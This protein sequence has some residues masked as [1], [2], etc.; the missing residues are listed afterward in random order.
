MATRRITSVLFGDLVGFTHLT[1]SRDQEDAREL[2]SHYFDTCRRIVERYG[3]TVEKF[4]GDA[5]MAV[6]G[7]P[8]AHEDDAERAV[9]AGLELVNAVTSIGDELGV[10]DLAMRVGIV[11]GEVAVTIGAEQQGM[12]AGDAVNT[13]ARVQSVAAPHQVWVDETTRL[14]TSA[15]ITYL[16]VGSHALKGKADPVPLW[17]V[18]AVVAAVGGAQRADG[19]E[20]PLIGRERELRMVKE[21]FHASEESGRPALL[22]MVGEPGVGKSRLAWEFEK[23]VD[24]LLGSVRWHSGRCVSYGE[25]VAYYALAEAFRGRLQML[26]SAPEDGGEEDA[27]RLLELGLVRYVADEAERD[28]LRPRVAALLGTGSVAGFPREDLFSA[29]TVFLERVAEGYPL[30]LVIDDAQHADDGLLHFVEHVISVAA[31][32]CFVLLLTRPGLV[33]ARPS[34]ATNHRATVSHL[35]VMREDEVAEL[36]D[37]LVAGVPASVR[38]SLVARSE[39]VPLFAVE[40]VRSLI[41]RD[42]VVP[43]GGQYVL[44]D[45]DRLDLDS[46]GAPASLQAL[47]SARL[48]ALEPSHRRLVD[49]ASVF[50]GSFTAE[51]IGALGRELGG[52]ADV[53]GALVALTRLQ[54]LGVD[55]NRFS[56]GFGRYHFVQSVVRQVAY[57]TLSRRDRKAAHLAV[58]ALL[59]RAEDTGADVA[60][61]VARH[62]LDALAAMPGDPDV[63]DLEARATAQ[64]EVAAERAR[65]LGAPSESVQHLRAAFERASGDD[66]RARLESALAAAMFDAGDYAGAAEHGRAATEAFDA[67]GDALSAAVAAAAWADALAASGDIPAAVEVV[68][69]RWEAL[70]D[71]PGSDPAL[72][73]LGEALIGATSRRGETRWEVLRRRIQIAERMGEHAH[74]ADTLNWLSVD[75]TSL[76]AP[77]TSK[78]VMEAAADLARAHHLPVSLARCLNNLIVTEGL[79]DLPRAL[80]AAREGVEVADRSGVAFWRE[81]IRA[82]LALASFAAGDWATVDE[83]V[84]DAHGLMSINVSVMRTL[85]LALELIRNPA[86]PAVAADPPLELDDPVEQAWWHYVSGLQAVSRGEHQQAAH[87]LARS[88]ELTAEATG[89]SDDLHHIWPAAVE[90]AMECEDDDALAR[91]LAVVD[92]HA[93]RALVPV[94]V[95]AHRRRVAGLLARRCEPDAAERMLREAI[96][97]FRRW[98]AQPYLARTQVELGQ[99]L[100][101]RGETEQGHGLVRDGRTALAELGAFGWLAR[102]GLGEGD[103]VRVAD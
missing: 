93:V 68:E 78:V 20:A 28:W 48:D 102:L 2:L 22:V 18:R 89:L 88:V 67:L 58:A 32:P 24:G 17:S 3:G 66:Q 75:F 56:A 50:G 63:A 6:W 29:W 91:L 10:P 49:L 8:S 31:F 72:L 83:L 45:P 36:I 82:N 44:A 37:G 38:S 60:A 4:I 43:R 81:Y 87:L 62:Y 57:G 51:Q 85:Q 99:W 11:T 41:D 70:Q 12:V 74:L 92:D 53:E 15:A 7:V 52:V 39:G 76:G 13:A 61:I 47:I 73:R 14:L 27:V 33:E 55:A 84:A 94:A 71:V 21:L 69:P 97:M 96:E 98:G 46:L 101:E 16:D 90:V 34:L 59:E 1:E 5:V 77:Y 42:L 103:R 9:R 30:V 40:T 54:I 23:Y 65:A 19:L 100:V 35:E 25:G 26:L 64:L 79:S 95:A 86:P 80:E